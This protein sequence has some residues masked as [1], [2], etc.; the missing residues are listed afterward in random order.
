MFVKPRSSRNRWKTVTLAVV[1]A[2][3]TALPAALVTPSVASPP[4]ETDPAVVIEWNAI[5]ARTIFAENMTPVPASNLYFGFVSIAT[6]DAVVAIEGGY[7]PYAY[8]RR[9]H[10]TALADVAAA[11]AA[12][13]V[14]SHY[15]PASASNL[16]ADYAAVAA[17]PEGRAKARGVR[18]GERAAAA[19]IEL[20]ADDGRGAAV[21]LDVSPE[22]GV[23]RPTPDA[24]APMAVPW[25]GFVEPLALDEPVELSGPNEL[26]SRAYA[27]EFD[28]TKAFGVKEGSSRTPAQTETALFYNDNIVL[29]YQVAMRDQVTRRGLDI[30]DSARAFAILNTS[31]ADAVISAWR[32]KFDYPT[33]RPISAIQLADT[34][35]NTATTADPAWVPLALNPP[36]PEYASGHASVSGAASHTFGYLFGEDSID[37]NVYSAVTSTTKH[38]DTVGALDIDTMNA[39]IWLGIHFRDSMIDANEM[40][41]EVS[42]EVIDD[43][44]EED[45]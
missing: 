12:H 14:L 8:E 41:H 31:I 44:F 27:R 4:T 38:Y 22:P 36:Y 5:A 15:F 30:V 13:R 19:I 10:K 39:R 33:W 3:G 37:L 24:F 42:D 40:G 11:T 9:A 2:A 29:Q 1:A 35:G 25:L 45:D 28:E 20:R 21:S 43:Y 26:G 16:A 6:Y 7:E 18:I 34:D 23:W 32:A 17:A